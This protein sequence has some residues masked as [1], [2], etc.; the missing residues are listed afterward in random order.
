MRSVAG[1]NECP[2]GPCARGGKDLH[3]GNAAFKTLGQKNWPRGGRAP[4]GKTRKGWAMFPVFNRQG[5]GEAGAR[6][7]VP[8]PVFPQFDGSHC[9]GFDPWSSTPT[10]QQNRSFRFWYQLPAW[11]TEKKQKRSP[12]NRLGRSVFPR[13]G[14]DQ[15]LGD[16]GALFCCFWPRF[17]FRG[18]F[19]GG[20][21]VVFFFFADFCRV[22]E[23]GPGPNSGA[24]THVSR[25]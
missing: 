2:P 17:R 9:P 16:C 4:A 6:K 18:K 12:R 24:P 5:A 8:T 1:K 20:G 23:W 22:N 15:F 21:A 10:T 7:I 11:R 3:G 14:L 25:I 19:C 13:D